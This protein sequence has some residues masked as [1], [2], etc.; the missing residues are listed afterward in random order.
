MP[1]LAYKFNLKYK[2]ELQLKIFVTVLNHLAH[3]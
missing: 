3:N 1:D 2:N